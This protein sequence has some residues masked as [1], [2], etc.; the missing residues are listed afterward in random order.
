MIA[1]KF[2]AAGRLATFSGVSWPEPGTWLEAKGGL[3]RCFSGVHALRAQ[4][5]LGWIDDELW[6]CE[7]SGEIEDDGDTLVAERGQLLERIQEWNEVSAYDLTRDCATRGRRRVLEALGGGG[8][9][10]AAGELDGLDARRF[11]ATAPGVAARLPTEAAGLVMMAADTT[12]LAER[13]RIAER[14]PYLRSHLEA[15]AASR[16]TYGAIAANVAFVISRSIAGLHRDG[17]E[18]GFATERAW[19]LDRLLEQLG[20]GAAASH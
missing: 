1:Y 7:L 13:L 3:E 19:Q 16:P 5:L 10:E 18:T 12:A 20:L 14:E 15:V 17:Y 11:A 2:L 6:T 9:E 4:G 8:H